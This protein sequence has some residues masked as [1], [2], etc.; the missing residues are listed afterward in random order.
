MKHNKTSNTIESEKDCA[1]TPVWFV[2][3]SA[4]FLGIEYFELDVAANKE[5]SKAA[6][7][8]SLSEGN[9]GLK[10]NWDLFNWCNPPFSNILPWID[11]A[12]VMAGRGC[13]TAMIM[14]DNTET[15]YVRAASEKADTIIRMPFRLSF[16][17]PD[18]SDFLDKKGKKQGPQF[19]V[20]L[21]WFTPLGLKV[22]T[23]FIY[24][25]FRVGFQ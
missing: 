21:A 2:D 3:S 19:P 16:L 4:D 9:D 14:P 11:R 15:K 12:E 22:P 17:K 25:D 8:L 1:Q 5:T 23:R 13:S 18:G 7:Y 6:S 24:H 20:L 10:N